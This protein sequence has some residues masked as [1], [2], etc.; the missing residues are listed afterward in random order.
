[1]S[2]LYC[3]VSCFIVFKGTNMKIQMFLLEEEIMQGGLCDIG[4]EHT[5]ENSPHH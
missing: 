5:V 1:M 3:E 2:E 4:G